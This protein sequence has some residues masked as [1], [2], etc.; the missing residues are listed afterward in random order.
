MDFTFSAEEKEFDRQVKE[1]LD[2]ERQR[3]DAH[4]IFRPYMDTF[5]SAASEPAGRELIKRLGARGWLGL[6]W[7]EEYGGKNI[8]GAQEY[9]LNE[10]LAQSG[11]P[12]TGKGVGLIGKTL[13]NHGSDEL[14][15]WFLPRI[16]R[17]EID[18]ALGYSEPDAGSDLASLKLRA[19]RTEGGWILNG[20]KRF[21]TSAHFAEWYW[22]AARTDPEAKKHEGI[23]LFLVDLDDSR[24]TVLEQKTLGDERTNEVFFDDVFV[25]DSHVVGEVNKGWTYVREALAYERFTI[26]AV[27]WLESKMQMI[28]DWART[29]DV[30]GERPADRPDVRSGIVDLAMDLEVARLLLL[31]VTDQ[32][33]KG[34]VPSIE[35]SMCKLAL[36]HLHQKMA[37]FM[38]LQLGPEAVLKSDAAGAVADGFWETSYRAT[39]NVTVG[40]GS[41]EIQKNL[42]A[43]LGLKLPVRS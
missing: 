41:T 42:L 5:A 33:L 26:Y 15:D 43:R 12:L 10:R 40:G 36:T 38:S 27:G 20:Q 8:R 3:D 18:F 19:T 30:D 24:L 22:V 35:A 37:R 1:F 14:K 39:V 2:G 4:L 25:P 6:T 23:T 28:V 29:P 7:P 11:A 32:G 17:G 16:L 13:M 21:T 9:L 31:Y 34:K